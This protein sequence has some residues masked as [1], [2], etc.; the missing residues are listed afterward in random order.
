MI[1]AVLIVVL[2][3]VAFIIYSFSF[4]R[5]CGSSMYPSYIDGDIIFAYRIY[6]KHRI[7]KGDV[8]VF[9]RRED[10]VINDKGIPEPYV[11]KRV[12]DIQDKDGVLKFY[13]LGDNSEDSFDSRYYGYINSGCIKFKPFRQIDR[14]NI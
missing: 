7:K 13:C 14:R 11:I 2:G 8:V 3:I 1:I 9:I 10:A 12:Q 5:V 6:N 4:V